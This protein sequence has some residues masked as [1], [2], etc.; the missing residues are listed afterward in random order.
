MGLG[1]CLQ[2]VVAVIK[3]VFEEINPFGQAMNFSQVNNK[4]SEMGY[5]PE[6]IEAWDDL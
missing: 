2:P 4:L 1:W 3:A 6:Q 5:Y